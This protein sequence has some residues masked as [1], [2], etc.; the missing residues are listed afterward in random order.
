MDNMLFSD[1]L[2]E[3]WNLIRRTNKYIDE[4]QPWVLC[5]DEAKKAELANAL[6]N[7]AESIR[8]ISI[9]IQPFMPLT[10]AKIWAQLNITEGALTDWESAKTWG[11]L[12]AELTVTKGET[13]FPRIDMKKE[14]E[15]L[16][17]EAR[18]AALPPIELE[19]QLTEKVDFDTFCKS[20]FRVVK[21]KACEAVKKSDKLLK[22]T[23]DD[24]SGSDRTIVSGIHHY[25]EPED[26]V[27]K[28]AVAIL[29]LPAR[30][31]MGIPS[32]GMLI[33]AVHK[34]KGEEKLHLLLLD[35]SIPA[36]AK[37]C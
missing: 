23:L 11:L 4:T 25:Y 24:G 36:G 22:F 15:A 19:P 13:L 21:V 12:P 18:K 34:E 10:P 20:D 37:L 14:L 30:K 1:A 8:I 33:S 26:L 31:M 35:D 17:A 3:I 29:N 16:E 27:G 2:I 6:Y 5:K 9:L 28:T 7:V 32:C